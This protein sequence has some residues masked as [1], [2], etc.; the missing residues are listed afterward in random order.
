M[1]SNKD[2]LEYLANILIHEEIKDIVISPG[3]R[4]A[5]MML[6][7]PEYEAFNIYSIIDERSAG[8]FALGI[9]Q[10]TRRPVVLNCTSGS[11]LLNYAPA[12]AEAYYQQIPLIVLSADRPEKLVD[13]GDGQAIRQKNVFQN[14]V[15]KSVHLPED[16]KST[17]KLIKYQKLVFRAI[18]ASQKPVMG[19]VHI[20]V[21]LDEPI[22]GEKPKSNI[23]LLSLSTGKTILKLSKTK[24]E[25][26]RSKWET[27]KKKMIIV[28]QSIPNFELNNCLI[29]L[30]K[31]DDVTVLT[32]TTS[33]LH[34]SLFIDK[35]DQTLTQINKENE[36]DFYPDLIVSMGG[37]I[38]SKKIKAWLRDNEKLEHWHISLDENAPNVFFHLSEHIRIHEVDFLK[39]LVSAKTSDKLFQ[40]LWLKAKKQGQDLHE[41]FL[42]KIPYS[43][44]MIF[45]ALQETLPENI[46]LHFA[47]STPVRYSQ[48]FNF[49]KNTII[50]SNRGVSGI[51]GS[52]S[53][54]LGQSLAF[55]G[56]T[57]VLTGDLSF[58]YDNNALWNTYLH[59]KFK[60]ILINN[61]GGGIFRFINGPLNSGKIDLFE[62]PHHRTAKR[63]AEDASM[64]YISCNK[65]EDLHSA[66]SSLIAYPKATVLEIFT[67][68][69]TNDK[70]LK[71]YFFYLEKKV[72]N[73]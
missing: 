38:V 62:T 71:E 54:A 68:R 43:D 70:V 50:D 41:V 69:E 10:K 66:I 63:L 4:N 58:F 28:G 13:Q 39:N 21:P 72:E 49:G 40:E 12:L 53:T 60:I 36:I 61:G 20:N 6:T 1:I 42:S 32:E 35:I 17:E 7:F 16:I 9:A 11:A 30:A 48:L 25:L 33:N 18:E 51:D 52:V 59:P 67:P 57:I 27:A 23:T 44:L 45:N 22:Y 2:G 55:D 73:N 31:N 56:Q 5:P 64:T 14:Y 47:N 19:P 65:K 24:N 34:S 3:S 29:D 37:H 8:F 26:I 15:R 46:Q